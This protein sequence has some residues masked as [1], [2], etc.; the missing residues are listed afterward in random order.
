MDL[1]YEHRKI[2]IENKVITALDEFVL[3]YMKCLKNTQ[4]M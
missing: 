3:D 1:K 4:T 2:I